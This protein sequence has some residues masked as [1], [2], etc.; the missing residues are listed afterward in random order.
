MVAPTGP[1]KQPDCVESLCQH[2]KADSQ[3]D[4]G[5]AHQTVA[6]SVT[7]EKWQCLPCSWKSQLLGFTISLQ[8]AGGAHHARI[9]CPRWVA[10]LAW[11]FQVAKAT[12]GWQMSIRSHSVRARDSQPFV[13][14]RDGNLSGLLECFKRG[15]ASPLDE[16]RNGWSLI[17]V[18]LC[19]QL[20][21]RSRLMTSQHAAL[22]QRIDICT[23]LLEMGVKIN[24]KANHQM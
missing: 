16:D 18:S 12:S 10:S 22:G 24:E 13:Y 5:D 20:R 4:S 11:D 23:R 14:I 17:H 19:Q 6:K 1:P 21:L 2:A 8:W 7:G 3:T 15:E 9:C